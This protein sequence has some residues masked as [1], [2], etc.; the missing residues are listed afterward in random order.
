MPSGTWVKGQFVKERP[1]VVVLVHF[2]FKSELLI[3][4]FLCELR[5]CFFKF[6]AFIVPRGT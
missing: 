2:D 1:G 4:G 6:I 3:N 5:K